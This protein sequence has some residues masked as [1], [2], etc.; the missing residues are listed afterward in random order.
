MELTVPEEYPE[1]VPTI[2]LHSI[3]G[4]YNRAD[5]NCGNERN[6]E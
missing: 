5:E 6:A 2:V 1:M 4:V 3:K